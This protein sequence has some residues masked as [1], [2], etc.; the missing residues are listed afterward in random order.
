VHGTSDLKGGV[1]KM[2]LL[3]NILFF[4]IFYG[5]LVI[6]ISIMLEKNKNRKIKRFFKDKTKNGKR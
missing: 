1:K 4:T 2:N 3:D 5:F 6:F